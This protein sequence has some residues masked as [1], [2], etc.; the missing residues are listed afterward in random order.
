MNLKWLT[1]KSGVGLDSLDMTTCAFHSSTGLLCL[2][3]VLMK[4]GLANPSEHEV[5]V[6]D[7]RTVAN[8]KVHFVCRRGCRMKSN[9]N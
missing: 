2:S 9:W 8:R 4:L 3:V 7:E 5:S 1:R 6:N